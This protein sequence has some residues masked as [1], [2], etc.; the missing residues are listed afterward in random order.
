METIHDTELLSLIRAGQTR[1]KG[2]SLL[3]QKYQERLYWYIRRLVVDHDDA[4]DILQDTFL[5]AW[6]GIEHFRGDSE[7]F[8]WLYRIATNEALGFLRRKN[9]RTLIPLG[10]AGND[11]LNSLQNDAFYVGDDFDQRFQK[12]LSTLPP[13]QKMIF[14]LK[15]FEEL[16]FEEISKITGVTVGALKASYHHAV[17]KIEKRME[18][19]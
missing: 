15:Y 5:K 8:T 2:F 18:P 3:V 19:D 14:S 4:K 12:A 6:N 9:M 17:K 7:I 16:K 1:Q 10:K 13:K 11:L